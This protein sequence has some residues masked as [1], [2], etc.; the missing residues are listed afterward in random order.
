MESPPEEVPDEV[1]LLISYT[2]T[3]LEVNERVLSRTTAPCIEPLESKS[4]TMGHD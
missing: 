4:E 3:L 2:A 1:Y